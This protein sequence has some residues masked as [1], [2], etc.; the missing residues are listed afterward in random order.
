MNNR[1]SFDKTFPSRTLASFDAEAKTNEINKFTNLCMLEVLFQLIRIDY[2]GDLPPSLTTSTV[3]LTTA[4]RSLKI[5]SPSDPVSSGPSNPANLFHAFADITT[6]LNDTTSSWGL[7]LAH[8]FHAALPIKYREDIEANDV[9]CYQLPN[10]ATLT[11]KAKQLA[12]LRTLRWVAV[13]ANK[14]FD[15]L[16]KQQTAF[17]TVYTKITTKKASDFFVS[18][19]ARAVTF[20]AETKDSTKD[21]ATSVAT[22]LF[23]SPAEGV[24]L[25]HTSTDTGHP[26]PVKPPR[27]EH[28]PAIAPVTV[29]IGG[30]AFLVCQSTGFQSAFDVTFRGCLDYGQLDHNSFKDCPKRDDPAVR[31]E[32]FSNLHAHKP[33][34]LQQ[35]ARSQA[36]VP[37]QVR[38]HIRT[39]Q[40][41]LP[42]KDKHNGDTTSTHSPNRQQQLPIIVFPIGELPDQQSPSSNFRHTAQ[43]APRRHVHDAAPTAF[44]AAACLFPLASNQTSTQLTAF[45]NHRIALRTW[46]P[47]QRARMFAA[48][49]ANTEPACATHVC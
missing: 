28:I 7:T 27:F 3:G 47:R 21:P 49:L 40:T 13:D 31:Q 48:P 11:T 45:S 8:Q 42:A 33:Q 19:P 17:M 15:T 18:T 38:A 25:R 23:A 36:T 34:V 5:R 10:P 37:R 39:P 35:L 41:K 2:V 30:K 4:I 29:I 1:E 20:T 43:S 44:S 12:A 14:R 9:N 16:F 6:Q 46:L 22:P 24:I 32:F 26:A